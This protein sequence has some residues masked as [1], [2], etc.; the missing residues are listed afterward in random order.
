[1]KL[2]N[3]FIKKSETSR[4]HR[5]IYQAD[6]YNPLSL[7]ESAKKKYHERE[8]SSRKASNRIYQ[9][10]VIILASK[11][12]LISGGMLLETEWLYKIN[13]ELKDLW[14]TMT[15]VGIDVKVVKLYYILKGTLR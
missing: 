14:F 12:W 7:K 8:T 4:L 9:H 1:M 10:N 6:C 13:L 3:G 11:Y 2:R 5:K 15:N